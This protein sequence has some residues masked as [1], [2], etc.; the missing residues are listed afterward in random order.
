MDMELLSIHEYP[1][2]SEESESSHCAGSGLAGSGAG[3]MRSPQF[4]IRGER[5]VAGFLSI[6]RSNK[7]ALS[8][9]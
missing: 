5:K 1:F 8:S 6:S 7:K 4:F 9:A 2:F 3:I